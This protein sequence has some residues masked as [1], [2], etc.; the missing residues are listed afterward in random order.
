[1]RGA[2]SAGEP[3]QAQANQHDRRQ[4]AEVE[5]GQ[6]CVVTSTPDASEVTPA[7]RTRRSSACPAPCPAPRARRSVQRQRGAAGEQEVPAQP[8]RNSARP[9]C[10][11]L[12][13]G[14]RHRDAGQVQQHAAPITGSVPKR[15]IRWPVKKP[16]ANMPITCHSQHQRGVGKRQAA[17]LHGQRRRGH[18]QVHH[19]EARAPATAAT[20][21]TGCRSDLRHRP[22]ATAGFPWRAG[23]K[24][25]ERHQHHRHQ[26]H[27]GQREVGAAKGRQQVAR[28]RRQIGPMTR[29]EQAAGHHQR[30]GLLAPGRWR[31]VRRP[32]S[33]TGTVGA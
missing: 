32:R 8:S 30:H 5:P 17:L 19:A 21:N 31:P 22:A 18:Q 7:W 33:G 4:R 3:G 1:M 25:H 15:L 20:M 9:K 2:V 16:G 27:T 10:V 6:P 11:Q 24:A 29:P 26:R 28:V 14:Q 12:H 13:A 23:R